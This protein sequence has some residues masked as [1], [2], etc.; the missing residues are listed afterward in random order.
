[1]PWQETCVQEQRIRFLHDQQKKEDSMAELCRRYGLS[2]RVGYKW[3]E[4][5]RQG[6]LEALHDRSRAPRRHPNQT[7]AA[8]EQRILELRAEHGRRGPTTLQAVAR[9][10]R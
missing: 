6:G 10:P 4:R 2:R 3:V 9:T 5:Y 1:M 7:P 8:I